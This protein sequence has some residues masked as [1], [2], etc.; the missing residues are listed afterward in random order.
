MKKLV[1]KVL[2]SS[3]PSKVDMPITVRRCGVCGCHLEL[4]EAL[5][6]R[7][8]ANDG[9][10]N[11]PRPDAPN[12]RPRRAP[13]P[14]CGCDGRPPGRTRAGTGGLSPGLGKGAA[15]RLADP[16][17][18]ATRVEELC[19]PRLPGQDAREHP[20]P[21]AHDERGAA[22]LLR[23]RQNQAARLAGHPEPALRDALADGPG[24]ATSGGD[25][26]RR[27]A[28]ERGSPPSRARRGGTGRSGAPGRGC[29][30]P[31]ATSGSQG[32]R[33]GR[34]GPPGP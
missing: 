15:P 22:C 34:T 20:R 3:C 24:A 8:G 10:N 26:R 5:R 30:S 29:G 21:M 17:D 23:H 13:C 18:G 28:G 19:L 32:A 27:P 7:T 14:Q 16:D 31:S 25:R 4:C 12:L 1:R 2:N 9:G 33:D 6:S 11:E